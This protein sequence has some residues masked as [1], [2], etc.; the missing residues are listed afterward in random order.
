[1]SK[2]NHFSSDSSDPGLS[3]CFLPQVSQLTPLRTFRFQI[4]A[5]YS[6]SHS[7]PSWHLTKDHS[8]LYLLRT[9]YDL[10]SCPSSLMFFSTRVRLSF[11]NVC[12]AGYLSP[13]QSPGCTLI[14]L[15]QLHKCLLKHHS[16]RK[17]PDNSQHK[18]NSILD[19]C[20]F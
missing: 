5:S 20:S 1:M 12:I 15:T 6:Y 16:Y 7:S 3:S 2:Y 13:Q 10:T 9:C 14:P 8:L 4:L 19:T 17:L 18:L 11:K